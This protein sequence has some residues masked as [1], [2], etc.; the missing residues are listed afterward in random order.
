MLPTT[1]LLSLLAACSGSG[2]APRAPAPKE[3]REK[4][5]EP[6]PPSGGLAV[7]VRA[8][9][10]PV[11]G[12]A[13]WVDEIAGKVTPSAGKLEIAKDGMGDR[14]LVLAPGSALSVR[15]AAGQARGITLRNVEAAP[16][17]APLQQRE[18]PPGGM[19]GVQLPSSG[20]LTL[21]CSPEPC[22]GARIVLG[23]AG[24]VTDAS[25]IARL[26]G[27]GVAPARVHVWHPKRGRLDQTLTVTEGQESGVE[28]V[29][30]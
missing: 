1:I 9:D 8:A 10:G 14:L 11:E 17:A 23:A 20:M 12:A 18:L 2:V 29:F 16:D 5:P 25:G 27:L 21:A 30:P 7:T 24:A 4:P 13:V 22:S 28:V 3:R 19:V 15:E 6:P 26:S